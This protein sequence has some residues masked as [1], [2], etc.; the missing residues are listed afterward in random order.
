[1]TMTKGF[2]GLTKREPI[3]AQANIGIQKSDVNESVSM[4]AKT[5]Y[6]YMR[7][8]TITQGHAKDCQKSTC[9]LP[10]MLQG[11]LS[12]MPTTLPEDRIFVFGAVVWKDGVTVND[13]ITLNMGATVTH[14]R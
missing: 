5:P 4:K 9:S 1:M 11:T 12:L 13:T 3:L 14:N 6:T 10:F 8:I 7:E 2:W